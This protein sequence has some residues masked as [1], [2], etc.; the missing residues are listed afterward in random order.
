MSRSADKLR[1][2]IADDE[3]P[4][5]SFLA[6][7]LGR[8]G[9]VDLLG[10]AVNGMEAVTL[11]ESKQPDLALLDLQMPEVDGLGVVR[12]LKKNRMPLVAFVTAYDE[13]AVRAFEVNAVDYILKPVESA[14][15]RQTIDRARERLEHEEYKSE[16]AER[17]RAAVSDYEAAG[18]RPLLE[19]IPVRRHDEIILVPVSQIVSIVAD[20]E[21]LHLRTGTNE[22]HTIA[23]RLR[24]LAV[25]LDATRFMRLS[26]GA[27]INV[28][29]I[30]RIIRMPGGLFTVVLNDNQEFPVSRLQSRLLRDQLLRL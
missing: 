17:V 29:T 24:D 27:I 20:G 22:T 10:E 28:D 6:A 9:D 18:V 19:R 4:A 3:R 15:L 13:Y 11:I 30:R 25:R 23:Y 7:I 16:A 21:I 1:V 8:F 5:R 26:R 2:V 14:R 12:L